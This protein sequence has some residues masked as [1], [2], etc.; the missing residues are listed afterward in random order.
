MEWIAFSDKFPRAHLVSGEY[1][2]LEKWPRMSR[3]GVLARL[4][5]ALEPAGAWAI[6][7][8]NRS[9]N[10]ALYVAYESPADALSLRRAVG[11]VKASPD[12][13]RERW[14]SHFEFWFDRAMNDEIL[15]M[16]ETRG[17]VPPAR[18]QQPSR[19]PPSALS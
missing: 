9:G 13:R 7:K 2:P 16:I 6:N 8:M 1:D 17:Q 19:G 18:D 3:F 12:V 14:L 10:N 15:R 11:A 4:V 5:V